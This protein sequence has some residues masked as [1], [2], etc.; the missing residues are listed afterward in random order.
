MIWQ[1]LCFS[2]CHCRCVYGLCLYACVF[3]CS[4]MFCLQV[5]AHPVSSTYKKCPCSYVTAHPVSPIPWKCARVCKVFTYV[6]THP[7][8]IQSH[9][10]LNEC[11]NCLNWHCAPWVR[12]FPHLPK[13]Q[14]AENVLPTFCSAAQEKAGK[15]Y[16]WTAA[17]K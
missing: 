15:N 16:T 6:S 2:A 12:H 13:S 3:L 5:T 11:D 14:Q 9:S 1:I 17:R 10:S 8:F 7:V 4:S